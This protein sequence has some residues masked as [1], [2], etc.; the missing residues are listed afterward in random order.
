M[1]Y[2]KQAKHFCIV[3]CIS[4]QTH[5]VEL[6]TLNK[7]N[8]PNTFQFLSQ[9]KNI[10][11]SKNEVLN[12]L[13]NFVDNKGC[14]INM[15]KKRIL[16]TINH[17]IESNDVPRESKK[18]RTEEEDW[19]TAYNNQCKQGAHLQKDIAHM[20]GESLQLSG[21]NCQEIKTKSTLLIEEKKIAKFVKEYQP[22]NKKN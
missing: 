21:S 15:N 17:H 8:T 19:L 4:L 16:S 11:V 1:N 7:R 12:I 14:L 9:N 5:Y 2:Q 18:P 20:F 22:I 13:A 6:E 10:C 3:A